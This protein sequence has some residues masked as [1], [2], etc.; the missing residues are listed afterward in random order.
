MFLN[1]RD[2]FSHLRG[3]RKPETQVSR[4][5]APSDGWG[6]GW[7]VLAVFS[8]SGVTRQSWCFSASLLSLPHSRHGHPF[9]V[10]LCV[11]ITEKDPG[12]SH[13]TILN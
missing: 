2:L 9:W 10:S 8:A 11:L 1:Y 3:G 7:R 4:G 13:I 12:G 6:G 5:W